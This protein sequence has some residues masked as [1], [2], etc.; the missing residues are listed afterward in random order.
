MELVLP[1]YNVHPCFSLKNFG[2]KVHI[3]HSKVQWFTMKPK[4]TFQVFQGLLS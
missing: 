1:M 3:I 4:L 2:G